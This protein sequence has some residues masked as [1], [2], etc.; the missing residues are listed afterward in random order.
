MRHSFSGMVR[1]AGGR[2]ALALWLALIP[3]A[4]ALGEDTAREQGKPLHMEEMV[5]K[6]ERI[7]TPTMQTGD[8]VNTGLEVTREGMDMQ[9]AKAETSVYNSLNVISGVNVEGPDPYA[10][11]PEQ[12][13]IRTRGVRGYLGAMSVEGVPNWGGN[14][15]GPREYLYDT[16]NFR[17]VAIYK[18]VVPADIGTGVG[19]RGGAIEL[20]PLWPKEEA[21]ATLS[22]GFGS[23]AYSRSFVR[24]DSGSLG[25]IGTRL[26][27]SYSY[28]HA[29]KW[30]GPGEIGPRNNGNVMLAQ[31]VWNDDEL[32]IFFNANN[33]SSYKYRA[34]SYSQVSHLD[35]NYR[36][37]FNS[38]RTGVAATDQ[39]YYG[40]NKGEYVNNDLFAVIPVTVSKDLSFTFKPYYANENTTLYNGVPAG[41]GRVQR[42][43][44]DIERFG[45]IAEMRTD[46]GFAETTLG[47]LVESSSMKI[48]TRNYTT[49]MVF[50]SYGIYTKS[51]ENAQLH[52]P[53][54][55]IAGAL[56]RFKWQAGLKYFS[57]S[58]P[59]AEGYTWA[60]G[61]LVHDPTLDRSAK[62][63]EAFLPS[64]GVSYDFTDSAQGFASYGRSQ[65]RPYSYV[66]LINIFTQNRAAFNAAGVSLNDLFNG[67]DM[68]TTDMVEAGVRLTYDWAEITPSVYY[69]KSDNLLVTVYDPRVNL[70]YQQNV[71]KATGYGF[72][73]DTNFHL[74]EHVSLFFNPSYNIL[75]YDD[76][77]NYAG[78]VT[79][80]KGRQVADTPT[81]MA[82]TGVILSY[83]G[84]EA[85]PTVRYVGGRYG[86]AKHQEKIPGYTLLDLRLGYTVKDFAY[87]KALRFSLELSNLLDRKYVSSINASDDSAGGLN[88]YLTGAPFTAMFSMA[89]D[90]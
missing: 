40:N 53:Y 49:N 64:A 43:D 14:P 6:E 74:G 59:S 57:Y 85:V 19:A 73:L 45:N 32:K 60:A 44:R 89:L 67:Y 27:G 13:T 4:Q 31:P 71:G 10:L 77:L 70:N 8:T 17:S 65:I 90:I 7:V 3:T 28:T 82:K 88:S 25:Q 54:V 84:F 22:Q 52:T 26:S 48:T 1:H 38:E 33:I 29:D 76:D 11:S 36:T 35:D 41:G 78:A 39:Y 9:G 2:L 5:V 55:K 86:D 81:I 62:T 46:L 18:G 79:D 61:T 75:T 47:Y 63:Y 69:T 87:T 37:D 21:G 15:I 72:E 66:P 30:K 51:S 56:D 50:Q 80:C 58:D 23:N 34:L 68:E 12:N 20:R 83:G 42:N 16:E 24:L